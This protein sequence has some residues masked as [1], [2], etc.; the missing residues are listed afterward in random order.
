MSQE[1]F[2]VGNGFQSSALL[3][4]RTCQYEANVRAAKVWRKVDFGHRG[5]PDAGIRHLIADQLVEFFANAFRDAPGPMRVQ[6][7]G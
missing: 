7:L 2:S 5:W 4:R 6:V 3:L 1:L